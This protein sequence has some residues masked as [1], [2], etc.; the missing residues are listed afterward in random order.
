MCGQGEETLNHALFHCSKV[1]SLWNFISGFDINTAV[2]ANFD[3]T[4][5]WWSHNLLSGNFLM[6][7]ALVYMVSLVSQKPFCS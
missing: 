2:L 4:I 5:V 6:A 3:D 7:I 1:S